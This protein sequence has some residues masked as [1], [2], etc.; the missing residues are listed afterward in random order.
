LFRA[1]PRKPSEVG[2]NGHAL[3]D[4]KVYMEVKSGI[5]QVRSPDG[6]LALAES[7]M[8]S[9]RYVIWYLDSQS[10]TIIACRAAR[11]KAK[12]DR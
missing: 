3:I 1:E 7:V 10:G 11:T 5:H 8:C 2:Y 6:R 12:T 4:N 9:E